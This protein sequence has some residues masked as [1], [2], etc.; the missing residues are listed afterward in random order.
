ML[1]IGNR[2]HNK[3]LNLETLK[4]IHFGSVGVDKIDLKSISKNVLITNAG[5]F[6][7]SV[8]HMAFCKIFELLNANLDIEINFNRKVLGKR[9]KSY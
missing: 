2:P 7:K 3:L 5:I 8:S 9:K 1:C 4:W 6:D